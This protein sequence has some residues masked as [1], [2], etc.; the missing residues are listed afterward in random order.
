MGQRLY[1]ANDGVTGRDGGPYLDE[2][3]VI[4]AEERRALVE[5][6]E[7][8]YDNPPATAGIQ[9]NTAAQ[10][11]FTVDVNRPSTTTAAFDEA[12]ARFSRAADDDNTNL[13]VFSEIPDDALTNKDADEVKPS[14][15]E[16]KE[17]DENTDT[18][19]F[20]GGNPPTDSDKGEASDV[21]NVGHDTPA[22]ENGDKDYDNWLVADLQTELGKRELSKSG[23]KD[24]LVARL[25]DADQSSASA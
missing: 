14:P 3:E 12:D 20:Q 4:R 2:V 21:E 1:N 24:E 8:D 18:L 25:K 17:A 19:I 10:M 16:L 9:L 23:N 11:M 15:E 6:R 7:P 22:T 13:R 5:G